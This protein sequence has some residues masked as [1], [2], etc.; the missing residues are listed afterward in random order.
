MKKLKIALCALFALTMSLFLFACGPKKDPEK[1]PTEA[2]VDEVIVEGSISVGDSVANADAIPSDQLSA[3][4][5]KVVYEGVE[6]TTEL[7][8]ADY[9]IDYTAVTWQKAGSYKAT[10]KPTEKNEYNLTGELTVNITHTFVEGT[11]GQLR[12]QCGA[13]QLKYTDLKES[14]KIG[15]WHGGVTLGADNK[16]ITAPGGALTG[17]TP[18][19]TSTVG[20]LDKGTKITLTGTAHAHNAGNTYYTPILGI[21]NLQLGSDGGAVLQRNDNYTIY[22]GMTNGLH[23]FKTELDKTSNIDAT[24][25]EATATSEELK[26]YYQGDISESK[27]YYDEA[28]PDKVT[29][30]SLSWEYREDGVAVM[31]WDNLDTGRVRTVT[32]KMPERSFYNAILHGEEIDMEFDT[33]EVVQSLQLKEISSVTGTPRHYIENE[34]FDSSELT[35]NIAY[36][37]KEGTSKADLVTVW[38]NETANATDETAGWVDLG[39]TPLTAKMQSFRVSVTVG[40]D[41]K[42]K[43]IPAITVVKN[44][45]NDDMS[46]HDVEVGGVNF[47]DSGLT[48]FSFGATSND[49]A[50]VTVKGVAKSLTDAQRTALGADSSF[51]HY[52]TFYMYGREGTVGTF[53]TTG[54][55]DV[56]VG[57]AAAGKAV[58]T[59]KGVGVVVAVKA[60]TTTATI[61]GANADNKDIVVVFDGLR[62]VSVVSVVTAENLSLN[63]KSDFTIVYKNVDVANEQALVDD[64]SLMINGK[65]VFFNTASS[66]TPI[67]Q[68]GN[69]QVKS[70]T[71][72][73]KDLTVTYTYGGFDPVEPRPIAVQLVDLSGEPVVSDTIY[74]AMEFAADNGLKDGNILVSV[75]GTNLY[76]AKAFNVADVKDAT[77]KLDALT[78]SANMGGNTPADFKKFEYLR[79]YDFGFATAGG[80]TTL[81]N[82]GT[83]LNGL[84]S[85]KTVVFGTINNAKDTDHGA[86]V[87]VTVD[88]TKLGV[89]MADSTAEFAF[90]VGGES[91]YATVNA[92]NEV[93]ANVTFELPAAAVEFNTVTAADCTTAIATGYEIG[94]AGAAAKFIANADVKYNAHAWGTAVDGVETCTQCGATRTSVT[95]GDKPYTYTLSGRTTEQIEN[96]GNGVWWDGNSNPDVLVGVITLPTSKNFVVKYT[97]DMIIDSWRD[98]VFQL[99]DG[100]G[101]FATFAPFEEA[102]TWGDPLFPKATSAITSAIVNGKEVA[103]D[104]VAN[105]GNEAENAPA[106]LYGKYAVTLI[107]L[108]GQ[109]KVV[110]NFERYYS[111]STGYETGD[112]LTAI[113][114]DEDKY[115]AT[116]VYEGFDIATDTTLT[117]QINGNPHGASNFT[118]TIAEEVTGDDPIVV[119]HTHDYKNYVCAGCGDVQLDK[120]KDLPATEVQNAQGD[121][122]GAPDHGWWSA[123]STDVAVSGDFIIK[124]T[125][126]Q[127]TCVDPTAAFEMYS[128]TTKDVDNPA[129]NAYYDFN[130]NDNGRWG[131]LAVVGTTNTLRTNGTK[132]T[133]F[134][135]TTYE[136]YA[137]R[138]GT[139]FV[140]HYR[141]LTGD[142]VYTVTDVT[143]NFTQDALKV[144]L[145]G[146]SVGMT[147]VKCWTGTI[148]APAEE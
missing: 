136:V 101:Q 124:Y 16:M 119:S 47:P 74:P 104:G 57:T 13:V 84:A 81:T 80:V 51:T 67:G 91:W 9:T 140:M 54:T 78:F 143:E 24:L 8:S 65:S 103:E 134:A 102:D 127:G 15:G 73:G 142:N 4:K 75:Q 48:D 118:R 111:N 27:D 133:S 99:K 2:K 146:F 106:Q 31:T 108:N 79:A 129:N 21:A 37:G 68:N 110:V 61:K 34:M 117:I 147:N 116:L 89:R 83:L 128:E 52:V 120:I 72:S 33:M 19:P 30:I 5:V 135:G 22:D 23:G 25:G 1:T 64:Y 18:P 43:S 77:L 11:D 105:I 70:V 94:G 39:F 90:N 144:H 76:L 98:I 96:V 62:G 123:P 50:E 6:G 100:N 69:V 141:V 38:A 17:V 95:V 3:I 131:T 28:E 56:V 55:F 114:K 112:T 125:F 88:L 126:E 46:G 12:C 10:V 130:P 32:V 87:V 85:V 109:M 97:Y 14:V 115:V 71:L 42:Y 63:S 107:W 7:T 20:Q 66:L 41:T 59:D 58:A 35:V 82:A 36:E 93:S 44:A 60:D 40:V 45:V 113:D 138:L 132:P 49:L 86:V 139:T 53:A 145:N 26:T 137:Y 122:F 148:T 29:K 121:L 92:S